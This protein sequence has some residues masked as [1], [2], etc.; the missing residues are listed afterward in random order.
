V[1]RLNTIMD[2][3]YI[4]VMGGGRAVEFGPPADLLSRNGEFAELV[5]STGPESAKALRSMVFTQS[6]TFDEVDV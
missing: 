6:V 4:L 1:R 5:D 3:D 2:N